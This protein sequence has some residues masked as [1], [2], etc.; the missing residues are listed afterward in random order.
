MLTDYDGLSLYFKALSHPTRLQIL[1]MLRLG[2]VCVCHIEAALA[3]RQAYVSQQL[4]ILREAGLVEAR[5]DGLQVFYRIADPTTA[6]LLEQLCGP[7]GA[8]SHSILAN[9]PC[10]HCSDKSQPI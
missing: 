5:K 1:D 8:A 9:C 2:E 3:K 10:P 7:L 6:A 4:M